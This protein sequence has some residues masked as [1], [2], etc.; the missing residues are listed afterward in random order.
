MRFFAG[1]LLLCLAPC[2]GWGQ[3]V[4]ADLSQTRVSITSNFDG[5]EILVF[6]AINPG[7]EDPSGMEVIVTIAGPAAPVIVRKKDRVA[8]IWV[9]TEA[10]EVQLAPSL[11]KIASTGPLAEILSDADDQRYRIT[12]PRAVFGSGIEDEARF[13]AALIR[14]REA[15]GLYRVREGSVTVQRAALFRTTVAL[16]ANLVEGDYTARVFLLRDKQVV[17]SFASSLDVRKVGLERWIYTLA[18]EQPLVYGLLSL[19]IAILAGWGASAI[20]RYFRG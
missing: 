20:F 12:V 10:V 14:I 17:A 6:G 18:H 1:L 8:G 5:S 7:S 13:K 4:V 15:N 16:P 11:Y 19:G 2:W 9:N 3:S